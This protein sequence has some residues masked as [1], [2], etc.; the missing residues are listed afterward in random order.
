[1]INTFNAG[2]EQM[3]GYPAQQV[4]GH[5]T[6]ESLHLASELETRAMQLSQA[7][8]KRIMPGQ[9]ML[10]E[11]ADSLHEAREWTLVRQD[12]SQL[13]VNMLATALLDDHGLWIGHLAICLDV[14]E[15][16]RAYE[17]LAARDRLLKNSVPMC[18]AGFSSSPWSPTTTGGLSTPATVCAISMKSIR[19][20]CNRMPSKFSSVFTPRC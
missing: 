9:A 2:A 16:K 4:L 7:L 19:G 11:G 3:L 8:G 6:L 12:G 17:A 20:C 13:T 18:R 1:M 15:Q 5:M 10:V 14:T